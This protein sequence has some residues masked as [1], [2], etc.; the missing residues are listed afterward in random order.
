MSDLQIYINQSAA[1][2]M[3][4]SRGYFKSRNCLREVQGTLDKKKQFMLTHEADTAKGGGPLDEIKI[5]LDDPKLR[6][7]IFSEGRRLTVWYRPADFQLVS[8]KQI[9]EFTLLQTPRYRGSDAL[10]MYVPDELLSVRLRFSAPVTLCV[11]P[12]NPGARALAAEL[13]RSCGERLNVVD[14]LPAHIHMG[15]HSTSRT[16]DSATHFLLYLNVHTFMAD[17]GPQLAEE[18]RSA[19]AVGL[20]V[21]MAH[22]N[23]A[24][25]GGCEY[26]RF[27]QTTPADLI[28]AGLYKTLAMA[29][30]PGTRHRA[31]S[32]KLLA[33]ALGAVPQQRSALT[34][35]LRRGPTSTSATPT[36][37][38]RV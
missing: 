10:D 1:V 18:L 32:M 25:R 16:D 31:V 15:V 17:A 9:A 19:C 5:E 8:L 34:N 12:H 36:S 33:K 35:V 11:S 21:V 27:F 13:E 14:K 29:I 2:N 7:A 26:A 30:Y 28:N 6:E 38:I 3:F 24:E 37:A 4:L 20:P 23:D 22:E